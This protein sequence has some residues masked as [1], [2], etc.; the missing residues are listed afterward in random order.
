MSSPALDQLNNNLLPQER[1]TPSSPTA[2]NIT[3][4]EVLLLLVLV[5]DMSLY[6]QASVQAHWVQTITWYMSIAH[7][8]MSPSSLAKIS[9]QPGTRIGHGLPKNAFSY[10]AVFLLSL[11]SSPVPSVVHPLLRRVHT[12]FRIITKFKSERASR[13]PPVQTPGQKRVLKLDLI[14]GVLSQ[15]SD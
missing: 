12:V 2:L 14:S 4:C 9:E 15:K 10:E 3:Q 13:N 11:L 6:V 8:G 7:Y 1:A 5:F